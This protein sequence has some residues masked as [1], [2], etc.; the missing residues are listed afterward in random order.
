[1][2]GPD[3]ASLARQAR[4]VL[5]RNRRG[6][7]TCP[8]GELYPHLWLWDSCFIAIG[9]ARYDAPRA[10]GE[11]RALFRGQWANGMLPHMIFAEG[12]HDVGSR[13]LWQ[14]RNNPAAPRDV[15]TSCITQPPLPAVAAA[16]VARA[17]PDDERRRFLADVYP[18][19]VAYHRWL[20]RERDLEGRGL[21]TL[22]HPWEC[23]LDTTPPWMDA[24]RRMPAPWW[25]R[26]ALG[27][28]LARVVRFLRRDTRFVPAAERPSDDDG[29][30]MLVL[31][32]R[33]KRN[34]FELRR[35]SPDRSLLIEDLAFNALLVV[36]NRCLRHIA[37]DLGETIDPD[38]ARCFEATPA[39]LDELWDE[40]TGQYYSRHAVTGDPL[41]TSTVATFMPLWANVEPSRVAPLVAL[42]R[43]PRRY[44]PQYPVPS[45]AVDAPEFDAER[46]WKGPTWINMNWV[47]VQ[48]L[49]ECGE[50]ALADQLRDRTLDLV[51]RTGFFE[52]FSPISGRGFGA[53]EFSW[54][55]ALV[56]DLLDDD[57]AVDDPDA[58]RD[59]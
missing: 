25:M 31:A 48:G 47:I 19:L 21:V 40:P 43:Q 38:L 15:E 52:Y 23:G 13:R 9:L 1:M 28:H 45:V 17:L 30:R 37:D 4:A 33:A 11:L 39:A 5:D 2:S 59:R 26:L 56:I 54:T 16:H 58:P 34:D 46:Y 41:A 55:A 14:S 7:W 35:L 44:G 18:R 27:L 49:R 50:T 42:L 22:I 53:E 32:R 57:H 12:V 20:Y 24:L 29:L 8:S 6:E 51:E 36:A 10:A 3:H